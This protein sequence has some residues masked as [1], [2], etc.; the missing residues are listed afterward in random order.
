MNAQRRIS[1][2]WYVAGDL[3]SSSLAW[4]I[5]FMLRKILLNE[6]QDDVLSQSLNDVKF[7][8]GIILI[9]LGWI[10]L[11][12]LTGSYESL[13]YKSRLNE[14]L[15]GIIITFLGTAAL[16]FAVIL[17]DNTGN[18]IYYYQAFL[19]L[20]MLNVVIQNIP[21]LVLLE[22]IKKQI[23]KGEVWFQT[24]M[25][26]NVDTISKLAN[27]LQQNRRW[28]GFRFTGFFSSEGKSNKL[29]K[30]IPYLG[31]PHDIGTYLQNHTIDQVI[32]A[33][34]P[35]HGPEVEN[36]IRTLRQYDIDIKLAPDTIDLLAGSVKTT[37]LFGPALIDLNTTL[38][39][40]WQRNIKR[41]IDIVGSIIGLIF[42]IPIILYAAFRIKMSS[43][44]PVF[45]SQERIGFKGRPFIIYKLRSMLANAEANGPQLS[46]DEDPRI[47][48]WGKIMRKW[49]IDELPQFLNILKGDMSLIGPRPERKFYI[50]Q[51]TVHHPHYIHLLNVK[52]GL[53]SW[54]MVKFGY[55]ENIEEMVE[56]MTYDL[57]YIENISLL[58]DFKILFH[59]LRI[60][61]N[62][63]GK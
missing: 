18:T 27:E 51:I 3:I 16:F 31:K 33:M 5:F 52:P 39:P 2:A 41:A 63:K 61:V 38:M 1:I 34:D 59:T 55:A 29:E 57:V 32:I 7:W 11:Y 37:N 43:N 48:P 20:W 35:R 54:G 14:L 50:D 8:L 30:M 9:P 26:G 4:A 40:K 47:T 12:A 46:S 22:Q 44:G 62:G 28:L 56:R 60:L 24:L 10:F 45:Y 25:I 53:T 13:Y 19:L 58:L 42:S 23:I 6:S 21:R 36:L 17:D 49:R 15:E